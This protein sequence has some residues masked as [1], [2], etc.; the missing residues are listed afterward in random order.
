[1]TFQKHFDLWFEDGNVVLV[2]ENTGF[3]V[4]RGILARDSEV[5]RDMFLLPQPSSLPVEDTYEG[6][7]LVRLADDNADEVAKALTI[8]FDGGRSFSQQNQRV[9]L[10]TVV[11]ALRIGTKYG[12]DTILQEAL[13]RIST[14]YPADLHAL[15][16]HPPCSS[17]CPIIWNTEDP[18]AVFHLARQLDLDRLIPAALY[19]CANE[20][21]ITSL[22]SAS[23]GKNGRLHTLSLEELQ[24]CIQARDIL[25]VENVSLYDIFSDFHPVTLC[26]RWDPVTYITPCAD[27]MKD[28]VVAAHSNG[29]TRGER[30]FRR[31][32]KWMNGYQ[33][34]ASPS[35]CSGCAFDL[36]F[37][38]EERQTEVW[39]GLRERFCSNPCDDAMDDD[40]AQ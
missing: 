15:Q 32:K 29:F 30:A 6:C 18:I 26:I 10:A 3:R 35:L 17:T 36:A 31:L 2:A 37:Q 33:T 1:M 9:D 16:K 38:V 4:Y 12:L 13:R 20:V 22:F 8:L 39:T 14:C 28:M 24:D 23:T 40:T 25:T 19:K 27:T 11:A 7:P 5:F 34:S 21:Q